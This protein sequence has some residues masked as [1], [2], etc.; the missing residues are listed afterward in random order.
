[1]SQI[2]DLRLPL[3]RES[4][5]DLKLG[6]MVRLSGE[7][8]VSIGLPTHRRLAEAVE[9]GAPLP[10]DLRDGAFFH[11]STYVDETA[12]GPVPL[13]LNPSTSTR[14]NPWM[15]A[16][17]RGLGVRLVGGKGG[18]DEASAA[19]LRECGC[20]Y[21]SFLGGG[22]HL[23]SASLRRVVAMNWTEY[24]SQFR[25]LTLEVEQLGPATVAI[26]AHGNSLYT[27]LHER[28]VARMPGILRDLD[29]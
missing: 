10:V 19:A 28:A 17:I 2:H 6:D 3:T 21:L 24:I 12:D 16:L 25:L 22:A 15:P 18:L 7:I 23:L 4:V 20:V 27:Q 8:T 13:Y 11:L 5:L 14:Y 9:Q 26:D 29:A 1:M